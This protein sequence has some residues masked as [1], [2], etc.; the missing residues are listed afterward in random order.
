MHTQRLRLLYAFPLKKLE[1]RKSVREYIKYFEDNFLI[2]TISS[3]HTK[4]A[5]QIKSAKKVY[6]NDNGFLNLGVNRSQNLGIRL[7]NLYF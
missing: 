4:V 5:N 7:G 2:T 3:Y 6:L 1:R